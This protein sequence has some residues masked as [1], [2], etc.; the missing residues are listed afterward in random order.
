[1]TTLIDKHMPVKKL[2]AK[3][4]KQKI[5]PSISPIIIAKINKKNKLYKKFMKSKNREDQFR[6]NQIKNEITFLTRKSKKQ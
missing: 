6:F 5:Q 1:M 3:E 4:Q 2:T